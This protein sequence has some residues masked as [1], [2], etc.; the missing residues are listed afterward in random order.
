MASIYTKTASNL[1]GKFLFALPGASIGIGVPTDSN[2]DG[3]WNSVEQTVSP[4]SKI[5]LTGNY[6]ESAKG[7][8][9]YECTFNG[10]AAYFWSS[11]SNNWSVTA[12]QSNGTI[13]QAQNYLNELIGYNKNILENNLMCARILNFCSENGIALPSVAR[14]NLYTLQNRLVARNQKIKATATSIDESES[15]SFGVYNDELVRFMNEPGIGV[16]PLVYVIVIAAIALAATATSAIMIYKALHA[17][18]KADFSYSNDLTAQL[19]K[20]LPSEVYQQL[21]DENAANQEKAQ[22]AIDAASGKSLFNTIKTIGIGVGAI[23]LFD[24]FMSTRNNS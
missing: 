2:N 5:T 23:W 9:C 1:A 11:E 3:V 20:F 19:I 13:V 4:N 7:D 10:Q 14:Q 21:M 18:A 6:F 16:L 17:E 22:K 12:I 15:P 8:I 24:K